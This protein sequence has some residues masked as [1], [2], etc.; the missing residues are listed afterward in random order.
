MVPPLHERGRDCVAEFENA[1]V[2]RF[3]EAEVLL[4]RSRHL[5]AIYLFGYS[6]EM[7]VK[8]AFFRNAGFTD[9]RLISREDRSHAIGMS[10]T[11]G[12]PAS[13]GPHDIAGWAALAV[14]AR[15]TTARPY[16][17]ALG[18][19]IVAQATSLYLIW[20]EVLRYRA[21]QPMPREIRTVRVIANWFA[22]NYAIL[23]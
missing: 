8:A 3:A 10:A 20:R 22:K 12:L 4:K 6:V 21:T 5:G 19:L 2:Q 1:A 14:A 17:T 13:P 15:L 9:G 18:N 23:R 7:R 11:L 16:E